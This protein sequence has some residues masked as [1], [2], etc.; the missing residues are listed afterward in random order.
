MQNDEAL[1]EEWIYDQQFQ[2]QQENLTEDQIRQ[3]EQNQQVIEQQ[4][5]TVIDNQETT[6]I[7]GNA[8]QN[9]KV[10][11][12]KHKNDNSN[13]ITQRQQFTFYL[14]EINYFSFEKYLS[15]LSLGQYTSYI[16]LKTVLNILKNPKIDIPITLNSKQE[17]SRLQFLLIDLI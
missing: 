7:V 16:G 2:I 12:Q 13:F 9:Q 6:I 4:H 17:N 10:G 15:Q 3:S 14:R 5:T 1:I 11:I 8:N